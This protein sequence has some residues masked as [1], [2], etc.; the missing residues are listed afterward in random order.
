MRLLRLWLV[1]IF[2]AGPI[3]ATDDSD[4]QAVDPS[5]DGGVNAP[6]LEDTD[7]VEKLFRP[8]DGIAPVSSN[9]K[10]IKLLRNSA[11]APPAP[12][13]DG[14]I[15]FDGT[16]TYQLFENGLKRH[17]KTK[18]EKRG[19][20]GTIS[21]GKYGWITYKEMDV[22]SRLLGNGIVNLSLQ[23]PVRDSDNLE[24]RMVGIYAEHRIGWTMTELAAAR[25]NV[26]LV[27]IYDTGDASFVWSILTQTK[28]TS[29]IA[30]VGNAIKLID[31]HL[32][33]R[34]SSLKNVVVIGE[35]EEK[36]KILEKYPANGLTI[37]TMGELLIAG[38]KGGDN[39]PSRN[40]INTI[41]FTSG[42][43]GEP[44]GALITH[45]NL[46]AAVGATTQAGFGLNYKDTHFAYLPP[47]HIF[48]RIVGLTI[49][50]IGGRIGYYG[51]DLKQ[52][53]RDVALVAPT[54]FV[55]VPRV[56]EKTVDKI[57]VE[58]QKMT[59]DWKRKLVVS[60]T[61]TAEGNYASSMISRVMRK[62]FGGKLRMFL[63]GGGFLAQATQQALERL[64][65]VPVVQG[66]GMTE[67]TGATLVGNPLSKMYE[68]V[69]V[70]ASCVEIQ[71]VPEQE[72]DGLDPPSNRGE[73]YVR[74]PSVFKGYFGNPNATEATMTADGFVK[75][76]DI[77]EIILDKGET[78]I[79]IVGRRKENFKLAS[80]NYIV[81]SQYESMYKK[82]ALIREVMVEPSTDYKRL[83]GIINI[84]KD[85]LFDTEADLN[86]AEVKEQVLKCMHLVEEANKIPS[87]DQISDIFVTETD[88][89]PDG[90]LASELYTPTLKL[91]RAVARRMFNEEFTQM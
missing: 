5:P 81:P 86:S 2:R 3:I 50:Y 33:A 91:K 26:T 90:P 85:L 80:G 59:P 77:V 15:G 67:T 39:Y 69:G 42:T 1:A 11:V 57:Q 37:I 9:T 68:V 46:I 52:L 58:I 44:K 66:Y 49:M 25:Q 14:P 72:T 31:M 43:T 27:P 40:D 20:F 18:R 6:L 65:R 13:V 71:I 16:S 75:T 8:L 62:R 4:D 41:C 53:S 55:G 88:F 35:I 73:L 22:L 21:D 12:L 89:G 74:G 10:G 84:H 82:C 76:G 48:E 29:V 34:D 51:G 30:S 28:L 64:F 32:T 78:A 54:I 19:S 45:G 79:R 7:N 17:K 87:A 36:M 61:A 47:A 83:V 23:G 60:A 63:S 70:P 38:T 24:W 56:Y